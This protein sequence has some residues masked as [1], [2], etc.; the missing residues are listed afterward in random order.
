MSSRT[1]EP[2]PSRRG[3]LKKIALGAGAATTLPI[4]GQAA[5]RSPSPMPRHGFGVRPLRDGEQAAL[6]DPNWKP[7]FFDEHQNETV[8]ALTELIIPQTDTPGAKAALV[9]RFMDLWLSDEDAD[10]QKVTIEGL[11]WIDARSIEL[12]GKPFVGLTPEQQIALLTPLADHHNKKPE[13]QFG[14][15]VFEG[16]K[17]FTIWGYY[18]SQAGLEQELQYEGDDYHAEF[19]GACTHPEHQS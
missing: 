14:R 17:D 10:K 6:D 2:D 15:K 11:A 16:L 1:K 8:I 13:D 7:V 9:N 5:G 18:S 4:L 3:A 19:P 12:H